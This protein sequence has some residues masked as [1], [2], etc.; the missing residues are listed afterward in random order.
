MSL[1]NW[2]NDVVEAAQRNIGAFRTVNGKK[3]RID[4]TGT[5]RKS[6]GYLAKFDANGNATILFRSMVEY[7][8]YLE[9]GVKGT[10]S[11]KEHDTGFSFKKGTKMVPPGDESEKWGIRAWMKS[12]PLRIRNAKGEFVKAT[13]ARKQSLAFAIAVNIK[14]HGIAP[15]RFMRDA[16]ESKLDDLPNEYIGIMTDRI[17]EMIKERNKEN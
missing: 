15:S 14:K 4:N 6:L 8:V 12:R 16:I 10:E 1:I 17:N 13:E 11:G 9:Y 5:L 7:G 2:G 3:R